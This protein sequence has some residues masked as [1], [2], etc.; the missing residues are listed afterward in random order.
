MT[1]QP[2]TI[3]ERCQSARLAK[4]L[5]RSEAAEHLGWTEEE[6]QASETE[7][8]NNLM[9]YLRLS[10]LYRV[11]LDWLLAGRGQ[12]ATID[13]SDAELQAVIQNW[14]KLSPQLRHSLF[15]AAM[16]GRDDAL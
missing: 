6:L 14:P 4:Q 1:Q 10:A 15:C 3:P 7:L 8:L 11:N 12:R 5:S 13:Y 16:Q 9:D 2:T